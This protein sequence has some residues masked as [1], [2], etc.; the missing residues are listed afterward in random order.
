MFIFL[1]HLFVLILKFHFQNFTK[2]LLIYLEVKTNRFYLF[3]TSFQI[4]LNIF[5]NVLHNSII[6]YSYTIFFKQS[7]ELQFK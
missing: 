1:L 3:I 4:I 2:F 5:E 7:L 6:L